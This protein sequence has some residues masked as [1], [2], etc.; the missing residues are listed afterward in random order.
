MALFSVGSL[1]SQAAEAS[2]RLLC[3]DLGDECKDRRMLKDIPPKDLCLRLLRRFSS[4]QVRAK[5]LQE[6]VEVTQVPVDTA[7]AEELLSEYADGVALEL[8]SARDEL[9]KSGRWDM[10]P[11][12]RAEHDSLCFCL[13]VLELV[14]EVVVSTSA[15]A[16]PR[17]LHWY[18]RHY[19]EEDLADWYQQAQQYAAD[20]DASKKDSP[21]WEPIYRL[22]L[23]DGRSEVLALL[24]RSLASRDDQVARV[25]DFLQKIPSLRQMAE[26]NASS[27]EFCHAI[28][29]IQEAAQRLLKEA[30]ADHPTRQLLEV[31]AGCAQQTFEANEDV[32]ATMGRN[33]V[34]DF[35]FAS[36]WVFP[37]LRRI[38][39]GDL[40]RAV[41]RRRNSE[42]IDEIDQV[43]FAVLTLDV[44]ELLR[45]LS[46]MPDRFHGYFVVHVVDMLYYAGRV[47]MSFETGGAIP[48]RDFHLICFAEELC[49]GSRQLWRVA[50]DYL[51][52]AGAPAAVRFLSQ[53]NEQYCSAAAEDETAFMEALTLIEDLGL[54]RSLGAAQCWK[55]AE[56]LRASGNFLGCLRW[57]CWAEAGVATSSE[58]AASWG[59]LRTNA[60][61]EKDELKVRSC[62]A[63]I[64]EMLDELAEEDLHRLLE[65][66][67]PTDLEEPLEKYPPSSLLKS[68]SP[69]EAK[70]SLRT[71]P[72]SG[73]LCFFVQYARCR[74]LRLS[75]RAGSSWAPV[76]TSLLV[77]GLA[78]PSI[79][80]V[81]LKEEL[82]PV[83]EEDPPPLSTEDVLL[84]MRVAQTS[85]AAQ[86]FD[87]AAV[88]SDWEELNLS[89]ST[90]LSRAILR[91]PGRF[92]AAV[93]AVA[94]PS[95]ASPTPAVLIS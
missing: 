89:L 22:A 49:R 40:L 33:W 37:D 23:A 80:R 29:E 65:A 5:H 72:Q 14:R 26:S 6:Q 48:P 20:S 86:S 30:P 39:L 2:A 91:G 93:A 60:G 64:S 50:I 28:R 63:K 46:S 51:R 88:A 75:G 92:G 69:A 32:A 68:L 25:C 18:C 27:M 78:S 24:Q 42:S 87:G 19:L 66:L 70:V 34:E 94:P 83:L 57:A 77:Q 10:N 41:A 15:P 67:T 35:I 95:W 71:L 16:A 81:V 56:Q 53:V 62:C 12:S 38:E 21:F 85:A 73:R 1:G 17:L 9:R 59:S 8:R 45:L 43:L 36:A 3:E 82:A 74:A 76:L 4:F 54:S 52:A 11:A 55:R 58:A 84:L 31:Y 13:A 44:P 61:Q 79:V 90:G 47:P 7:V